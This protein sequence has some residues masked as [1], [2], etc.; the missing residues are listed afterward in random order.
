MP[1]QEEDDLHP[2]LATYGTH[3]HGP[4]ADDLLIGLDDTG[5]PGFPGTGFRAG[6]L[7]RLIA[8]SGL[9]QPQGITRHQLLFDPRIPYTD[10][11]SSA[12]ICV[13]DARDEAAVTALCRDHLVRTVAPGADAGLCLQRRGAVPDRLRQWGRLAKTHVLTLTGAQTL[14]I[15]HDLMLDGISGHHGGMIGALAAVGLHCDGDDG[16]FLWLKG[17]GEAANRTLAVSELTQELHVLP[18]PFDGQPMPAADERVALGEWPRAVMARHLPTLL[19][20]R[21]RDAADHQWRVVAAER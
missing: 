10:R 19:L 11:N 17:L 12:C 6:E 14:A 8:A 7:A 16:H 20:E 18:L 21:D 2:T 4:H 13:R 15:E 1:T 9:G 3:W 5:A